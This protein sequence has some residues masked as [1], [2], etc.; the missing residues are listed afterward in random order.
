MSRCPYCGLD[1]HGFWK[2][3]DYVEKLIVALN[4]PEPE[5]PI[6]AAWLLGELKDPRAV[7]PLIRLIK[8]T[9][10][11]YIAQAAVEAL[12]KFETPESLH[13]LDTLVHHPVKMVRDTVLQILAS[14]NR[15]RPSTEKGKE[16][17]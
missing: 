10:D 4:H 3:K 17:V 16:N 1:I 15:H 6:R 5:T 9:E 7:E 12:G 8:Y 2:S 14:R 11:V 13:F